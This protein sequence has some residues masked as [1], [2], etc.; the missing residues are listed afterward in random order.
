MASIPIASLT[1]AAALALPVAS[2]ASTLDYFAK[3]D[4][5][6]GSGVHGRANLKLDTDTYMLKVHLKA[7]GLAPNQ[8][9]VQHIHGPIGADGKPAAAVTPSLAGGSDLD[10]DG[11]IELAE[12]IPNY[13]PILLNLQNPTKPGFD[14]FPTAPNGKINF[15]YT[16]DL[17][18]SPA[19]GDNVLTDDPDDTF[20]AADLLPLN[21][22]E[23]VIHGGFLSAGQGFGEG[24]ADGTAGYKTVLPVATGLIS[25]SQSPSP[26]PVPL[27]ASV[28]LVLAGLGGLGAI[29]A[30]RSGAPTAA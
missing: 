13:G 15:K 8:L 4:P 29:K 27:P 19:F 11:I 23:I 26:S 28:W 21:L 25:P 9:H 17:S 24:E 7:R 3:L 1:L 12:A 14:G 2:Q 5:L 16:Y 20:S 10:G 22:R 30:R 18:N 6:N